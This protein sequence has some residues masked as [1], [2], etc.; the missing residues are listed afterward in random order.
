[1][2]N[3]NNYSAPKAEIICIDS[4]DVITTSVPGDENTVGPWVDID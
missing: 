1:M 4:I 3:T 2:K